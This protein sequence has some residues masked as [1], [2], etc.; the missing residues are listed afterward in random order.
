MKICYFKTYVDG[1]GYW[2]VA[3]LD[4]SSV[5][6]A[7]LSLLVVTVAAVRRL[8]SVLASVHVRLDAHLLVVV[9]LGW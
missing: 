7:V 4:V 9:R 6:L 8:L 2:Y 3:L 1:V 5:F